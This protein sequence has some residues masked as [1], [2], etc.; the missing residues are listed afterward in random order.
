MWRDAALIV[1]HGSGTCM[2]LS[3]RAEFLSV[4]K[5]LGIMA[6][7]DQKDCCVARC[8]ARRRLRQWHMQARFA[9]FASRCVPCDCRQAQ[10]LGTMHIVLY[11]LLLSAGP[12]LT[13]FLCATTGAV[14]VRRSSS[15]AAMA[16][17]GL[18]CWLRCTPRCVPMIV[19]LADNGGS[20][21]LVLLVTRHFALYSLLFSSD[22]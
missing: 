17:A 16:C 6:G 3:P 15:F 18:V 8:C 21:L 11:S 20:T 5:M 12:L 7:V 1:D 19:G 14:S 4:A 9:G 13:C 22:P 10:M 2:V